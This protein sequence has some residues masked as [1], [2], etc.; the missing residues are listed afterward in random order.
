MRAQNDPAFIAPILAVLKK[1]ETGSSSR[2]LRAGVEAVAYLAR[3]E[4]DKDAAY[5]FILKQTSS[6]RQSVRLAAIEALGTL[7]D[8]RAIPVLTG[9]AAGSEEASETKPA[10]K[11]LEAVRA[12]R[13]VV[14][15]MQTLR[16]EVL[17]LKKQNEELKSSLD[18][19]KKRVEAVV[20]PK[21][22]DIPVKKTERKRSR[23]KKL[24]SR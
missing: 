7:E 16:T 12:H 6:P 20:P 15:E 2:S 14:T 5:E 19:L 13:P 1:R 23:L 3:N 21:S 22:G 24:R 18:E 17:G 4:E 11:A 9:F 8:E 10:A